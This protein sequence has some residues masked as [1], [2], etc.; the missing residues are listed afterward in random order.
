MHTSCVSELLLAATTKS[1]RVVCLIRREGQA[2]PARAWAD[3][4]VAREE[5]R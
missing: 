3:C 2:R 5:A 4:G 1:H